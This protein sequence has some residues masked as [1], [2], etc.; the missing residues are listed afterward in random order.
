[1]ALERCSDCLEVLTW[2]WCTGTRRELDT[3]QGE[4]KRLFSSFFDVPAGASNANGGSGRRWLPAMDLVET[5]GDFVLRGAFSRS[6]SLPEGIDPASL[7][8]SFDSGVLTVRIPKPV[9]TKPQRVKIAVG[10]AREDAV[11]REDVAEADAS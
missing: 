6:L 4:V 3:L 5:K 2:H 1:V 7:I 11:E 10:G 9:Q 8:A